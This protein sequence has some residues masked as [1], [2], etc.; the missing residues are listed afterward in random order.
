M[1]I[2]NYMMSKDDSH[3]LNQFKRHTNFLD[4]RRNQS[5]KDS[6]PYFDF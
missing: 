3:L 1:Y 6:Y 4:A 5:F 2:I